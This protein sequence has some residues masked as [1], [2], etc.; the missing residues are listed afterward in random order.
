MLQIVKHCYQSPPKSSIVQAHFLHPLLMW[1]GLKLESCPSLITPHLSPHWSLV[2]RHGPHASHLAPGG[3]SA[4]PQQLAA[5]P[6]TDSSHHPMLFLNVL[7]LSHN[8]IRLPQDFPGAYT[9]SGIPGYEKPNEMVKK[10]YYKLPTA[11][12]PVTNNLPQVCLKAISLESCQHA[13]TEAIV[14]MMVRLP[15]QP[16]KAF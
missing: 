5:P 8:A 12:F 15:G 14:K 6:H 16:T 9:P 2:P 11:N 1:L 13:A 3:F 7:L 10:T 4:V